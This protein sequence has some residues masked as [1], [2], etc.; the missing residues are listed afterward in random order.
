M[1]TDEPTNKSYVR[2]LCYVH[3]LYACLRVPKPYE[4]Y[5]KTEIEQNDYV[6]IYIL[7][8]KDGDCHYKL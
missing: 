1:K 4:S 2:N 8:E 3:T 5:K 7:Y 6:P